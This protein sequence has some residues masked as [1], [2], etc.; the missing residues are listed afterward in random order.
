[1]KGI[2][3]AMTRTIASFI[4]ALGR[5]KVGLLASAFC[6]AEASSFTTTAGPAIL[7][8]LSSLAYGKD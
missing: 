8:G 7:A 2:I 1:M 5:W 4:A 6:I 3:S